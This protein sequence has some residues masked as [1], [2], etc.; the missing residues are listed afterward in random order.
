VPYDFLQPVGL[1]AYILLGIVVVLEG[2]VATLAGAVAASAGIMN[3][4]GVFLAAC[5]GNLSSDSL[6]YLLGYLGKIDLIL[7]YARWFGLKKEQIGHL[8]KDITDHAPKLLFLAKLTL[9]FSIPTLVATGMARVPMRRWFGI[10]TVA[11][12]IWT[13]SLVV[14]G[15]HFGRYLRTLEWGVQIVAVVGSL[16]FVAVLL[17]YITRLRRRQSEIESQES[18]ER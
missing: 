1:W 17:F 4:W 7:R 18:E 8:E 5:I 10:L 2:P 9:G 3:P 6:W 14:M 13:G 12:T 15:Y 11:E 16:A